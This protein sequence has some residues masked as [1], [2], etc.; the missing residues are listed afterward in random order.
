MG[1]DAI[2]AEQFKALEDRVVVL[3]KLINEILP[4]AGRVKPFA[5]PVAEVSTEEKGTGTAV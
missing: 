5:A 4:M 3:E 1:Y 2:S